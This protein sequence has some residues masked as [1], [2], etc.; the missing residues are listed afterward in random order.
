VLI[1][2]PATSAALLAGVAAALWVSSPPGQLARAARRAD[3]GVPRPTS[4]HAWLRARPD[5]PPL[6]RRVLVAVAGAGSVGLALRSL[7]EAFEV[8]GWLAIPVLALLGVTVLGRLEPAAA[9]RRQEQLVLELPQAL[10]LL[11]ACLAAG[12]PLRG[13]TSAVAATFV[14]PVAEDLGRVLS[15]IALGTSDADAWRTLTTQPQWAAAAIDLAR[16]VESGTMMV[17]V[18]VHHARAAREFRRATLEI[19]A[20]SVGVRSVLPLMTCFLP[21]FMLVGIIPTVA[22][23]VISALF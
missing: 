12:M 21:A 10:E 6:R 18:L 11:S 22:S 4:N 8:L 2:V 19:R 23:A 3:V 17:D 9:R 20:K 14:G 13:A 16:S 15:L 7:D 1:G 5:A